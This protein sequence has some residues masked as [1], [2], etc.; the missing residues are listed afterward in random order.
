[1]NTIL[2]LHHLRITQGK[3]EVLCVPQLH[4]AQGQLTAIIGPNGAGK[5]TLLNVLSGNHS[6]SATQIFHQEHSL[7][8]FGGLALAQKRAM[9]SQHSS[10]AFPLSVAELVRLG[11]EPYRTQAAQQQDQ[12]VC[13]WAMNAMSLN[14]LRERSSAELSGGEQHRA[15][16]ARVLAQLLPTL[17]ADLSDKWL[18][19]DEPT[20][21]LDIHHQYQLFA[22]L[23]Q[24]KMR[25][26]SIITILHDP[27]LAINQADRIV[28]LKEGQVFGECPAA[29]L[30]RSQALDALY[31][32]QMRCRYCDSTQQ[33][34]LAPQLSA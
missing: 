27:A 10:I 21:H 14:T 16:I 26:L 6:H 23:Q 13:D 30:A 7:A 8:Q 32:M 3:R 34:Y 12:A 5:S 18:L 24:L 9:L 11:R 20:N 17:D 15:H 22:L 1:M 28:M 25:G 2:K 29:E 31:G 33:Y 4:I 19:L